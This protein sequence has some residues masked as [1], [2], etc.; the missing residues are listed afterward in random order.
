MCQRCRY[1][2]PNT[3]NR[4]ASRRIVVRS[5]ISRPLGGSIGVSLHP[6]DRGQPAARS[7]SS[8]ASAPAPGELVLANELASSMPTAPR[9]APAFR[10]TGANALERRRLGVSCT[11]SL[12]AREVERVLEAVAH[13]EDGV[14]GREL[15][16]ESGRL[17]RAAGGPVL[18]RIGDLKAPR[19]ELAGLR[20]HIGLV[21]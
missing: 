13:T 4:S 5:P 10:A 21:A 1:P 20:A 3:R 14:G 12:G 16:V 6:A 15:P 8:A 2:D 17:G 19:V 9:A 11:G 7:R 18:V